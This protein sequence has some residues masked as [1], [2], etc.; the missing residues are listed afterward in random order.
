MNRSQKIVSRF[1]I[2]F[3]AFI[4]LYIGSHVGYYLIEKYHPDFLTC[5]VIGLGLYFLMMVFFYCIC[6]I[7]AEDEPEAK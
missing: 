6:A 2:G 5:V 7:N 4:F 3:F 1:F